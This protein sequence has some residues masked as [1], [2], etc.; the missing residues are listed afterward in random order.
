MIDGASALLDSMMPKFNGGTI[1]LGASASYASYV[2]YGTY[3]MH[4]R[5]FLR[6]GADSAAAA[7]EVAI[8]SAFTGGGF[9]VEGM[10]Q[11]IGESAKSTAEALCPVRT[12]KLRASIYVMIGA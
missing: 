8:V 6:P 10:M 12:G 4:P 7:A 9:D 1:I 5:P 3:K 2:E 11:T